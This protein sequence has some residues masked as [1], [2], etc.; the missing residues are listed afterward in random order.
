VWAFDASKQGV[1]A[2][3]AHVVN[4]FLAMILS[5]EAT[6]TNPDE[7]AFYFINFFFDTSIG[8]CGNLC[9]LKAM[10]TLADL[11]NLSSLQ[12]T[13]FYGEPLS[14]SVWGKQLAAWVL[15]IVLVKAVLGSMMF[16]MREPLAKVGDAIFSPVSGKPDA[17]LAI[18]MIGCPMLMNMLQFW[19]QDNFL[20]VPATRP[21]HH[22]LKCE[23]R[24][25]HSCHDTLL[26]HYTN[27][28]P[29]WID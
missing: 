24:L 9:L 17:E 10:K 1:G 11:Y 8:V 22:T 29:Y 7:C 21:H 26:L 19:I 20:K 13:G 23:T 18:V 2:G 12:N 16:G 14:Y 6:D 25:G 27:S 5:G 3:V 4:M 15:I 28:T